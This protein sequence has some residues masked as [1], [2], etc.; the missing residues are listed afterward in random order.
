MSILQNKH[1][2][3]RALE[4]TDVDF[5]Y[6][7]ENN[8][9]FWHLS[10]TLLPYS[11][12][13]LKNYI[14]NAHEDIYT[15]KQ[16][17]FVICNTLN[18]AVGLLDLFDFDPKNKKVGVGIIVIPSE[19]NKKIATHSLQLIINYC[20]NTLNTH[21]VYANILEDNHKSIRLFETLNFKKVGTK[22]DWTFH[23]GSYHNEILYQLIN[24]K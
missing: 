8:T 9:N 11:K 14:F 19:Q 23:N 7:I 22:K 17:R 4:P 1:I 6:H 20:F 15:A 2:I 24:T 18:K 13:I 12:E 5:L 21:Q 10:N 3:L 16:Y